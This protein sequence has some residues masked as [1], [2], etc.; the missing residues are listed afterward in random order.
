MVGP[1]DAHDTANDAFDVLS[2]HRRRYAL[3]C[4]REYETPLALADLADEVAVR[5]HDRPL[6]E[7]SAE[8]VKRIYVSLYHTH[9]PKLADA[10]Y[11]RY[12]QERDEVALL[13]HVA[14][15]E[16]RRRYLVA[17]RSTTNG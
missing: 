5:E 12:S 17:E 8:A 3:Q 7:I 15:L 14:R 6:P 9:V 16:Q 11:V 13:D 1:K 2:H 10:D 4:L